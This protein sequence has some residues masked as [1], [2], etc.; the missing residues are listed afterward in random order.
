MQSTSPAHTAASPDATAL[1]RASLRA[2]RVDALRGLA[3]LWMAIYHFNFDLNHLGLTVPKQRF[4]VEPF[5][6]WQ[7]V[8]ILSLFLFVAGV[9]LALAI[10]QQQSWP[11]FFKRWLQLVGAATLVS[12]GSWWVFPQDWIW[13]GVLHAMVLMLLLARSLLAI[14]DL[15]AGLVVIACT[16]LALP[17][18]ARAPY[19]DAAWLRWIGLG[20]IKPVTQDWVPLMPWFGVL[21]LGVAAGQYLARHHG[22]WLH[23][24]LGAGARPLVTLGRWS[25]LFYLLH[26]PLFFAL[27]NGY[28]TLR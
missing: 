12:L 13:F 27:L 5:W 28:K 25:L 9:A 8:S 7:R 14:V 1:A 24:P 11:Q 22:A 26:Q 6:V 15:R 18:M 21:L 19:W 20:V 4:F 2:E 17:W 10:A 23:A 3:V 16:L